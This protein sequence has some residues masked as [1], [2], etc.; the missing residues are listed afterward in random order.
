MS[1]VVVSASERSKMS[2]TPWLKVG[3]LDTLL[4]GAAYYFGL[5]CR[6]LSTAYQLLSPPFG[7]FLAL[8]RLLLLALG[9]V[10]VMA[11]IAAALFRPLWVSLA[12]MLFSGVALLQGLGYSQNALLLASGYVVIALA[13]ALWVHRE[14]N[15]RVHFSLAAIALVQSLL[16]F[17]LLGVAVGGFYL[18]YEQEIGRAGFSIP[19]Q[20]RN[21]IA[22]ELAERVSA[23]F[24]QLF[25]EAVREGVNQQAQDL[26][27]V[28]LAQVLK[29]MQ[30]LI[31][32]A[33][34]GLL[35]LGLLVI[36]LL[37]SWIPLLVIGLS[38]IILQ[39]VGIV[40]VA[41]E[42]RVVKRMVLR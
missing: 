3:L 12:A 25:Q 16:L 15:E 28:Q 24:P 39:V 13:Y 10:A 26:L 8:L 21:Q 29:P 19:A 20:Y 33:A 7:G 31:P 2:D 37:L 18:G 1:G 40:Q 42:T 5:Q 35:L 9:A 11:G 36:T 6:E 34:A 30:H 14:L 27:T 38:L 23:G 17:A 4:M 41:S 22:T 32:I